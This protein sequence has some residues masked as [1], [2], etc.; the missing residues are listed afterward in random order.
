MNIGR[1]IVGARMRLGLTQEEVARRAKTKQGR[2]SELET[3]SGNA[4][5]DTLDRIALVL[6]LEITLQQRGI[7]LTVHS[8]GSEEGRV[9]TTANTTPDVSYEMPL[10]YQERAATV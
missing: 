1:M 9:F 5:L 8:D 6:G 4:T 7:L 3:L 10:P 2:V